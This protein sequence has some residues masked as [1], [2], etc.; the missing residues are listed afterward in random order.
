MRG[1]AIFL[2]LLVGAMTPTLAAAQPI[3]TSLTQCAALYAVGAEQSAKTSNRAG[4]TGAAQVFWDAAV[5]AAQQEGRDKAQ[6]R[7]TQTY[8]AAQTEWRD[9]GRLFVFSAEG[10]DWFTY[11]RKLGAHRGLVLRPA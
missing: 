11:C 6:D 1:A 4:L 8:E 2:S 10:R 9:K 7:L 5:V 3:S